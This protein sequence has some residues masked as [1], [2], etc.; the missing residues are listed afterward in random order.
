MYAKM[1]IHIHII[2][3]ACKLLSAQNL[4]CVC[5][6]VCVFVVCVT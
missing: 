2:S 6:C 1:Y 4:L 5:V 3:F